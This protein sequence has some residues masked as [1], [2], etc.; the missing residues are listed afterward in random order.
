MDWVQGFL[1]IYGGVIDFIYIISVLMVV[2]LI[3][4]ERSDPKTLAMW[5]IVLLLFPIFGF[6]I[7]LFFGQTFYSR[8]QFSI[9][10]LDDER[11]SQLGIELLDEE[12]LKDTEY[13]DPEAR[14]FAKGM[15]N[16]GKFPYS[17]NNDVDLYTEGDAFYRDLLNDLRNAKKFIN[18]EYYIVRNDEL[19]NE[20]MDILIKKAEEGVE[21][22]L[23]IDAIGNN[24]GPIM[25]MKA[26]KKAGGSYTLFHRTITVLLSPKKNNRNH[27]KIAV[28]DGDIGYVSGFNI[29]DEYLGK[30]DRGYWR[31]TG[32]KIHGY[33]TVALNLRF[34]MDW[35]YATKTPFDADSDNVERYFPE[36]GV[37]Y[38]NDVVQIISGGPDLKANLI[39]MQYLKMIYCAKKTVYI[40]TPYLVPSNDV[41]K[42]L[43]LAANSGVDVR[44]IMLDRPDHALV[45]WASLWYSM[46]LMKEGVRIFHYNKGFIHSKAFVVDGKYCSVGSANMD[47]RSMT[48]NF[49]TN[50]LMYSVRIGDEM[51]KAFNEDLSHC[52]E[53]TMEEHKKLSRW[54]RF[55]IHF[56][57]LFSALA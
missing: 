57:R 23:M 50:A 54:I 8:R 25:K 32:V 14:V 4:L 18:A 30:S 56:A 20:F 27:R 16:N 33:S 37:N 1:D 13:D 29:G 21:V 45:F 6:I 9:K 36:M 41:I 19:S 11:L 31:D 42:A 49:E 46:E 28:I 15:S 3:Y 40:H 22:R 10:N 39:E 55:K 5:M 38:G 48:M 53:Y 7:Y 51:D 17:N 24:S 43:I 35:G 26:L 12:A 34:F 44:I 47:Q 52:T 2:I